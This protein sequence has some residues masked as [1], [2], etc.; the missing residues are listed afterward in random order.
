MNIIVSLLVF[1][2]L[3]TALFGV[4][5]ALLRWLHTPVR[6]TGKAA[7]RKHSSAES[8]RATPTTAMQH[9]AAIYAFSR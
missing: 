5:S 8:R 4:Y 6:V 3:T 9:S 2:L 1:A 7:K